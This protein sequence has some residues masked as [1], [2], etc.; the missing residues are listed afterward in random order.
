[1]QNGNS[2]IEYDWNSGEKTLLDSAI[3]SSFLES[4]TET[5]IEQ[6][7]TFEYNSHRLSRSA[8]VGYMRK[9]HL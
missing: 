6:Q 3:K 2:V 8:Y 1:M 5:I 9:L 7:E 4:I